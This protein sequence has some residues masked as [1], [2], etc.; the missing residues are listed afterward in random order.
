[1]WHI[2]KSIQFNKFC[3]LYTLMK[4]PLQ[5]QDS[6]HIHYPGKFPHVPLLSLL[7]PV[8]VTTDLQFYV[9]GII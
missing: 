9:N 1:M 3:H 2:F 8:R 6:E 7:V 5:S 4:L